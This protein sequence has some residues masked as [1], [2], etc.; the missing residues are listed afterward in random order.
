MIS[1]AEIINIKAYKIEGNEKLLFNNETTIVSEL[2]SGM[3]EV[4]SIDE[5]NTFGL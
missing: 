1:N 5:K 2:I 3:L 4:T